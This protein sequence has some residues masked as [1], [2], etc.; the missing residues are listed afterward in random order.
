M[1]S[2]W[3]IGNHTSIETNYN[4]FVVYRAFADRGT[5]VTHIDFA[6]LTLNAKGKLLHGGVELTTPPD[7]AVFVQPIFTIPNTA[8]FE[9]RN[10]VIDKLKSLNTMFVNDVDAHCNSAN[11]SM[12]YGLIQKYATDNEIDIP[13]PSIRLLSP[14]DTDEEVSETV[15]TLGG[16]PLVLKD[17]I[18]TGGRGAYCVSSLE[19]LR[20]TEVVIR[21]RIKATP[22]IMQSY[23][24]MK[25]KIL[26][27]RV[28]GENL[29]SRLV[30]IP[31][32]VEQFKGNIDNDRSYVAIR[33]DDSLR[34]IVLDTMKALNL[35]LARL[36]VF[37]T[38][39]G[40]KICEANSLG[41]ILGS[42]TTWNADIGGEIADY[43]IQKFQSRVS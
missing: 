12:M 10:N 6:K 23:I 7:L 38:D 33:T 3:V 20:A 31:A 34:K 16:Y 15:D 25:G 14:Q 24:D 22:I 2:V 37:I 11:K 43:C 36:D 40:Y 32:S 30:F 13:V 41:S 35:D 26:D 8:A 28:T 27:V 18:N 42:E 5:N 4:D 9:Q 29:K 17:P 1:L 39:E 19:E 21:E